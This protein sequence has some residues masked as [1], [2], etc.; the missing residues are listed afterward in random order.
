M[1]KAV[2]KS[3]ACPACGGQFKPVRKGHLYCSETCRKRYHKRSKAKLSAA[4]RAKRLATKLRK[5]ANTSFGKYL[6]RELRRAGNLEVLRGHSKTS[7]NRLVKLRSRCNTVSGYSSGKPI[8]TYELSHIYAS[9]G[10][11]GL[12]RLHPM[13]LVIAPKTFN[14]S[15]GVSVH[16]DWEDLYCDY[17]VID[18]R[19]NLSSQMTAEQVLRATRKYLKGVFD[20]WLS[21]FTIVTTQEQALVKELL[22][23]GYSAAQLSAY[24]F[25]ELSALAAKKDIFIFSKIADSAEEIR[26]L[27]EELKRLCP[28]SPFLLCIPKL[29]DFDW[30]LNKKEILFRLTEKDIKAAKKFVCEQGWRQLHRLEFKTMWKGIDVRDFFTDVEV[31]HEF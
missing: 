24:D 9:Q 7:L 2:L 30:T 10:K 11:H 31:E 16:S 27:E 20:D 15:I 3:V 4:N 19:W 12:G 18:Q 21:S 29:L 23:H 13:N 25:D 28:N 6:I 8:G 22:K 17:S 14:R 5:L 26:V 1:G